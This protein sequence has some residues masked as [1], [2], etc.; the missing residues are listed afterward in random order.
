LT[1]GVAVIEWPSRATARLSPDHFELHLE[2]GAS[3]DVRTAM[4]TGHGR[5]APRA[6]RLA[7]I[8]AFLDTA[9][10]GD[11]STRLSYAQGDASTRR[12]AR[13]VKADGGRAFLMDSPRQPDGPPVRDGK[14]YSQ[15]AHLAE[16][17][18]AFVAVDGAL[19]AAGFSAPQIF[20][21]DLDAG[22]LVLEDFGDRVF[23]A[24]VQAGANQ[25]D[26]WHRATDVLLDLRR[27]RPQQELPVGDG[28]I[29][30]LPQLDLGALRIEAELLTDWYWPALYGRPIP[31]GA[32]H[33]F[34]GAWNP[35]F[36]R[37]LKSPR[38][39]LLRDFHSPNLID[40]PKRSGVQ[41]VGLIDFQDA[42]L[43]PEAYDLVSL[44]QDARLDV[45]VAIESALL[46]HYMRHAA[47]RDPAFDAEDFHFTYAAL[48]AQRNTKILGIF[49][50][51]AKRDGKLQY[52]AHVPRIW[53]YLARDLDHPQLAPL[54]AW[55]D[56]HLP[57]T[58]RSRALSI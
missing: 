24:Q 11:A 4:L 26:L 29:Y 2:E 57:L 39:W 13:L 32:A 47:E 54:K 40:L 20:A 1:R 5:A 33:D 28:M 14:P 45:P 36:E 49:A 43:G 15:I 18:R 12:Y 16:D 27:H 58:V 23:G 46:D 30:R 50:R 53:G 7:K 52:L 25:D 38:G 42:M 21:R 55:Y 10:W 6:E 41:S 48:G 51:L 19:A 56:L 17:V 22:L 34:T 31:D 44:L 8:R 9:G 3:D 37:L 35:I